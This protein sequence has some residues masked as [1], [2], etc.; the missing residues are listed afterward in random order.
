MTGRPAN[1]PRLADPRRLRLHHRRGGGDAARPPAAPEGSYFNDGDRAAG[2]FGV[3]ATGFSVLLGFI[4][5]L[6]FT[7][8]DESRAGAETEALTVAQQ[9][10]TAQFFPG[11]AR[12]SSPASSS[13]TPGRSLPGVAAMRGRHSATSTRGASRCSARSQQVEPRTTPSSP[14]TTSGSTRPPSAS[15]PDRPDPRRGG[16]HPVA[17]VA[18]AVPHRRLI[19]VFML[20]FA[21]SGE[22]AV[23]A[24]APDGHRSSRDRRDAAPA[25]FLDHPFHGGHRRCSRSRWS[26]RCGS[27]TRWRV[28]GA[29]RRSLATRT[30]G[31]RN[32]RSCDRGGLAGDR[33]DRVARVRRSPDSVVR[34]SG[35][36]VGTAS[37]PTRPAGRPAAVRGLACGCPGGCAD[38]GRRG[39]VH[40]WVEPTPGATTSS[41]TSTSTA[42]APSSSRPLRRG[43]RPSR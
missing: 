38:A 7:S 31:P 28:I 6:A 9:F 26:A 23:V 4:V 14:R 1:D 5:F 15:R 29:T 18:R 25:P 17:A 3:L 43:S 8:Y 41:R 27:S 10:E 39:D 37:R 30:G 21:D 36:A 2:V 42:S 11:R 33:R 32:D 19:F 40:P 12:R 22:R 35:D 20:F 34:L 16:R 13:A 24:G